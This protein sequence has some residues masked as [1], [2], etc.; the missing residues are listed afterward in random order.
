MTLHMK[1]AVDQHIHYLRMTGKSNNTV[2]QAAYKFARFQQIMG[3]ERTLD[4]FKTRQ[5]IIPYLGALRSGGCQP[6]TINNYLSAL[7]GLYDWAIAEHLVTHNP[8]HQLRVKVTA[9]QASEIPSPRQLS[10]VIEA[11]DSPLYRTFLTFQL[12][13]G[14]RINEVRMLTCDAINLKERI[15]YVLESKTGKP[16][17]IPLNDQI[18]TVISTYLDEERRLVD[19]PYVFPSA[20]GALICKTTINRHLTTAAIE[21]LGYPVTSHT[22]RH[23]FTT[24][25][26]DKGVMETTLSELLGHAEPKTTRRYIRVRENHLR[27]AVE[28]LT[29]D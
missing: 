13:T 5:D 11:I 16:R 22:L 1:D 12:H 4:D 6:V 10:A 21:V 15:V 14:M 28:R 29:L 2:S 9:R 8:F 27:D 24:H 3:D 20:R 7:R 17:K 19:S 25:L 23:A 18:Y 26:Y